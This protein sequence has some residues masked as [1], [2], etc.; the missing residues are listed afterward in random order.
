[1][2]GRRAFVNL[3]VLALTVPVAARA[4]PTGTVHRL[5]VLSSSLPGVDLARSPNLQ[6]FFAGLYDL[7]WIEGRNLLIER[8]SPG[9]QHQR[10]ADAAAELLS[11]N[12]DLIFATGGAEAPLAAQQVTKTIPIVFATTD[13]PV[14]TGILP[15]L[16]R[17]AANVTGMTSMNI[18]LDGKRLNLLREILPTAARIGVL[19]SPADKSSDVMLRTIEDHA[20]GLGVQLHML[21]VRTA[22]NLDEAFASAKKSGTAG[23]LVLGS[24][25]LFGFQPR[26]AKVAVEM[27]VPVVSPFRD[28]PQAGGLAS[29]G[30]NTREMFRRA[31]LY[32]DK[33]LKG[34]K[35]AD[36]PVEQPTKFDLVIN[37]KAAKT[38]GLTIPQSV[39]LRADEVIQ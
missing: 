22:E 26:V 37:L 6:A 8:R 19:Y 27:R 32:V 25:L 18:E 1:M 36:L 4:Q 20:R 12:V 24:A 7:G 5:G 9:T 10:L 31:A 21:P 13:D 14:R 35:P 33:I 34:A 3:A 23:V 28:L 15:S 29:Y 11:L 2:F 30:V 17:P 39:L 16:A 38:L